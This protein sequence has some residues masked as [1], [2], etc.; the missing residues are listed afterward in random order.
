ME[1]LPS[2]RRDLL[3]ALLV[4][5]GAFLAV[6]LVE[7]T[8]IAV[9]ITQSG[10]ATSWWSVGSYN[11][12]YWA[13]AGLLTPLIAWLA[14]LLPL[15]GDR[16]WR[17]GAIHVL[18]AVAVGVLH[19]LLY[20]G[21]RM[22][23]GQVEPEK[24]W[25]LVLKM[26][27]G[28]MDREALIYGVVLAVVTAREYYRGLRAQEQRQA[29][30][31][32]S[33]SEARLESLKMQLQ[34]HF[35]FNA[36]HGVS[37]LIKRGDG[38]AAHDALLRLS[39]FLRLTLED[40]GRH[41]VP[42]ARERE[43]LEAYLEVQRVRYGDDLVLTGDLEAGCEDALVPHLL[44]QP[45]AENSLRH[46]LAAGGPGR[47]HLTA[48]R[49]GRRLRLELL[50][51]GRGLPE[52]LAEG[53]GLANVRARLAQLY[54]DDHRFELRNAD[55]AGAVVILDLPWRTQPAAGSDP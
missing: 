2:P 40:A 53:R 29:E 6:G 1:R 39:D 15:T 9:A 4:G 26:S 16:R 36:M 8:Q 3:R 48:R 19:I 11:L 37:T 27:T 46:G 17:H 35:L 54:P 49:E 22:L 12:V 38:T 10:K 20:S 7:T 52:A 55:P 21:V 41:E 28:N 43:V 45:L 47:L 44:L 30:L 51:D 34:P 42:L 18:L 13:L 24:F 32:A 23:Q 14:G 5:L 31:R 25:A 50:D 33:L